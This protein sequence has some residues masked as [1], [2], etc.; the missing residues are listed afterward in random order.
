MN[1]FLFCHCDNLVNKVSNDWPIVF[2]N[3][4]FGQ[5]VE[6]VLRMAII[7]NSNILYRHTYK[8]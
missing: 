3:T 5:V 7:C 6:R 2:V 8:F 1:D 4:C